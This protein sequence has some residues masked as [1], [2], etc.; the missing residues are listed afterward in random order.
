MLKLESK[1]H[2]DTTKENHQTTRKKH[3][4]DKMNRELQN[5]QKTSNKLADL[6]PYIIIISHVNCQNIPIKKQT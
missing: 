5:K 3:N 4:D 1:E 6:G 2:K